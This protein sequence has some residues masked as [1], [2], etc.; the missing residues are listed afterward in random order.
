MTI[1]HMLRPLLPSDK[2][3]LGSTSNLSRLRYWAG[4]CVLSLLASGTSAAS[5]NKIS[6]AEKSFALFSELASL[7]NPNI[8]KLYA[9]D[10]R[11]EYI[12]MH[13][14]RLSEAN[15]LLGTQYKQRLSTKSKTSVQ[16]FNARSEFQQVD[17]FTNGPRIGFFAL[18]YSPENCFV[19]D[20]YFVIFERG[21]DGQYQIIRERI[22]TAK[23]SQCGIYQQQANLGLPNFNVAAKAYEKANPVAVESMLEK[24]AEVIEANPPKQ[25][26]ASTEFVSFSHHDKT[27]VYTHKLSGYRSNPQYDGLL[28][29]ITKASLARKTCKNPILVQVLSR[30]G[31][32][33]YHYQDRSAQ[34][35][36]EIDIDKN[37]CIALAKADAKS[38]A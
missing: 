25:L 11:I 2:A 13:N 34:D 32:I 14:G 31:E 26:D 10:A 6:A 12:V 18:R 28:K 27:M 36:F 7:N 29:H 5:T 35:I 19:D 17:F 24:I 16:L 9:D 30:D 8:A 4:L 33:R 38:R 15:F 23:T 22:E 3:V 20:Q 21:G 37:V 1:P